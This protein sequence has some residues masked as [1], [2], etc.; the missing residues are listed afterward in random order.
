MIII[1]IIMI[2]SSLLLYNDHWSYIHN[3]QIIKLDFYKK[4]II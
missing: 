3:L 4:A 1:M 2:Q